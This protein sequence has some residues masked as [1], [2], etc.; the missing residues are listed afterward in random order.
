MLCPKCNSH[1]PDDSIFC[2]ECGVNLSS[3]GYA[4]GG[5]NMNTAYTSYGAPQ[6]TSVYK[7]KTPVVP[8]VAGAVLLA[9]IAIVI[10]ILLFF[11]NKL[12]HIVGKN[13]IAITDIIEADIVEYED[14][15]DAEEADTEEAESAGET[16]AAAS[17]ESEETA[18]TTD[19]LSRN[20]TETEGIEDLDEEKML[21]IAKENSTDENADISDAE[22]F[23]IYAD[24][25]EN[26]REELTKDWIRI[27]DMP[28]LLNGGWRA[29]TTDDLYGGE[30][31]RYF[32]IKIDTDG[33]KLKAIFNWAYLF[34]KTSGESVEESGSDTFKGKWDKDSG[35]AELKSSFATVRLEGFYMKPYYEGYGAGRIDWA[36]G[37]SEYLVLKR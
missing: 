15:E 25:D 26:A 32:N 8:I 11:K 30:T 18:E 16:E 34:D 23:Y 24:G 14:A 17:T 2:E 28:L 33:D 19:D 21:S 29:Y 12:E 31:E 10:V 3:Y 36:S 27:D 22:W 6:N 7:K 37:E 4:G 1:I 13:D 35:T 9:V 5:V 20:D